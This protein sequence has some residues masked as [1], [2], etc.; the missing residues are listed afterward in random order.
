MNV[1]IYWR[2]PK[3]HG[4][5]PIAQLSIWTAAMLA[6]VAGAELACALTGLPLSLLD[7]GPGG[8]IL[9]VVAMTS[10]LAL[11]TASGRPLAEYGL[12]ATKGWLGEGGLALAIGA[13]LYAAC[14]ACCVAVGACSLEFRQVSTTR[15]IEAGFA[16]LT[17]F[18]VAIT[19]QIVFGALL[20]GWL[21][22]GGA[23]VL[24]LL[25]PALLFGM[26]TALGRPEGLLGAEGLRL[27]VGMTL[28]ATFLGIWRL[29]TG[30]IV[31]PAGF[32]AGCILVR[33]VT[34]KLGLLDFQADSPWAEWMAPAGDPRQGLLLWSGLVVGCGTM[35]LF[36]WRRGEG[37]P[38]TDAAVDASFKRIVPF[39][40]LLAFAPL[41]VWL[42]E[43][44]RARFRVGLV[45]LPRLAFTLV[46][47]ALNSIV[48]LPERLLAPRLL[49]H[50]IPDPVF[51]VGMHRS[52]TT[53]L[54]Q[55]LSL[56]PQ[57]RSPRNFEVFNPHGF[58]SA[59]T[60]TAALAPLLMWR[61]PMDAVQMTPFSSQEEEFALA[62]MGSPSPY[63]AFCFPRQ[64]AYHCRY[65]YPAEFTPQQLTR[66]KRD[67]VA[68]LRKITWWNRRPPLL[69]NPINTSRVAI[70]KEMFPGAKFIYI[71]RNPD[72]VYRSNLHFAEHGIAVFQLQPLDPADTYADRVLANYRQATDACEQ[73]L[74]QLPERDVAR[75]RF[76]DLEADP[77]KEIARIFTTLGISPS[78][79]FAGRLDQYLASRAGYTKNRFAQLDPVSR[80]KV[81][82]LMGLYRRQWG[83]ADTPD[84][85]AA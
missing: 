5:A 53:H 45:Y 24:A 27:F 70:L 41:D 82:E 28:L 17:S 66:W 56:D 33:K 81:D 3:W 59:W 74:A 40:N 7:K 72:A 38:E 12:V 1:P 42:R 78:P 60:T 19:Q 55:L 44:W 50:E 47:S 80:R 85:R 18:P 65:W 30:T 57:F 62:A 58:L 11:V 37:A 31:G 35:G 14:C 4:L 32:L 20:L 43:F 9:T 23:K 79:S 71:V 36:L 54:H 84:R 2:L 13:G 76:E 51:I 61:R 68:F 29:R 8:I 49:K 77:R 46:A 22:A 6:L 64:L 73:D 26:A 67:Y 69:K 16:G 52:G 21:R 39:S 75:V 25:A 10:L 48:S 83:Y 63:W 15:G 34:S